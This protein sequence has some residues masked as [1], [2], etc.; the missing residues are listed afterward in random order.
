MRPTSSTGSRPR[1]GRPRRAGG[2]PAG[3]PWFT[4]RASPTGCSSWPPRRR[5][6]ASLTSPLQD[7]EIAAYGM[8]DGGPAGEV[9]LD[10]TPATRL[11]VDADCHRAG[12]ARLGGAGAVGGGAGGDGGDLRDADRLPRHADA[13]RQT[14]RHVPGAAAPR[15]GPVDRDRAGAVHRHRR[16]RRDGHAGAVAEGQPVQAP[17][18]PHRPAGRGRGDPDAWRHRD[19]V[20]IPGQPLRQAAG[21]DRPPVRGYRSPSRPADRALQAG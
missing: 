3:N 19:D 13:V 8:I 6:R 14:H 12:H 11:D 2:F 10:A 20:G 17:D 5:V 4:A 18:R 1:R 16:R 7:A 21:D 15:R 9:T